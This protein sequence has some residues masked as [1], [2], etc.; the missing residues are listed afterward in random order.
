MP[1]EFGDDPFGKHYFQPP[2]DPLADLEGATKLF[3]DLFETLSRGG[4]GQFSYKINPAE[5]ARAFQNSLGKSDDWVE[6]CTSFDGYAELLLG[7]MA[8]IPDTDYNISFTQE[9]RSLLRRLAKS[10]RSAIKR[11]FA[12]QRRGA[13]AEVIHGALFDSTHNIAVTYYLL[14]EL[15]KLLTINLKSKTTTKR[16][17]SKA[18]RTKQA[19]QGR[20]YRTRDELPDPARPAWS[21]ANRAPRSKQ[22]I[23]LRVTAETKDAI[24]TASD[25]LDI[26]MTAWITEAIEEKARRQ[27][28]EIEQSFGNISKDTSVKSK[29]KPKHPQRTVD[30]LPDPDQS[31]SAEVNRYEK[32]VAFRVE[33]QLAAQIETATRTNKTDKTGLVREIVSSFIESG[34]P[35]PKTK[36]GKVSVS[37]SVGV[38]LDPELIQQIDAAANLS[39]L[40][41]SEWMRRVVRWGIAQG[42]ELSNT[43]EQP[44]P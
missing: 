3:P 16:D 36:G 34:E 15:N 41:K 39:G 40:T 31:P 23:N 7:Q 21:E 38:R 32:L 20:K 29:T 19:E 35:I 42:T 8:N 9:T 5:F 27:G 43:P 14:K 13:T 6:N 4:G 22:Q 26:G 25:Q 24:Q 37:K 33:P 12:R 2:V 28:I 17:F 44:A 11:I 18:S 30:Q 1:D 10:S